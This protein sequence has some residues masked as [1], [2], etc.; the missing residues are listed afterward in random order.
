M[1]I[2]DVDKKFGGTIFVSMRETNG[3]M[4]NIASFLPISFDVCLKAYHMISH[5]I[6][7]E[8]E[9]EGDVMIR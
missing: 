5:D 9:D 7:E 4:E 8:N 3:D 1:I 6:V 2:N